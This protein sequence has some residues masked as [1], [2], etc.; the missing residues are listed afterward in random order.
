MNYYFV[1]Y[2]NDIH[3]DYIVQAGPFGSIEAARDARKLSGDVVTDDN[4]TPI[5]SEEWLWE[6]ER[7]V[8]D[9]YARQAIRQAKENVWKVGRRVHQ[10]GRVA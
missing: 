10:I 3:Y 7:D 2:R 8:P 4:F 1:I 5:T 6:W 9:C